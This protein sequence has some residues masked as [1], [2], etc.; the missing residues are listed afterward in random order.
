VHRLIPEHDKLSLQEA[1]WVEVLITTVS[2][3][4]RK[5]AIRRFKRANPECDEL[6]VTKTDAEGRQYTKIHVDNLTEEAMIAFRN[7]MLEEHGRPGEF[8]Y[9]TDETRDTSGR[10]S[11]SFIDTSHMKCDYNHELGVCKCH[12]PL[13]MTGQ[14]K[15]IR[16]AYAQ[17]AACWFVNGKAPERSKNKGGGLMTSSF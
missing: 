5:D 13:I 6:P 14:D 3:V 11:F 17:P 15:V 1:V 10:Y 4:A 16:N 7:K 2:E 8:L 12:C 9:P